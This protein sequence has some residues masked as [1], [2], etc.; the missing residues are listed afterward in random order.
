MQRSNPIPAYIEYILPLSSAVW[1]QL[2]SITPFTML[3]VLIQ[4][5]FIEITFETQFKQESKQSVSII[6]KSSSSYYKYK[7]L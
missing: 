6:T 4:T 1:L 5:H 2:Y 7:G 3:T